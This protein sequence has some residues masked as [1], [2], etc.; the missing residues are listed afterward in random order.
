MSNIDWSVLVFILVLAGEREKRGL[1]GRTLINFKRV[2]G[3]PLSIKCPQPLFPQEG[4][5]LAP[6][7]TPNVNPSFLS[8][9]K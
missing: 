3:I 7:L 9:H 2:V 5:Q 1:C 6:C 4:A 8:S